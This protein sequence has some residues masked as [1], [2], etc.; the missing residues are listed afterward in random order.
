MAVSHGSKQIVGIAFCWQAVARSAPS[1]SKM[2]SSQ[3][4][5]LVLTPNA[6]S[7]A[8]KFA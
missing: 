6:T 3:M 2:V 1:P 7:S 5:E 4:Q 8:L